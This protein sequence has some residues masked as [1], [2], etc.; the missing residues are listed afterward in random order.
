MP[1]VRSL[2][3][4]I[5]ISDAFALAEALAS[6]ALLQPVEGAVVAPPW[7]LRMHGFGAH[8]PDELQA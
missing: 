3:I 2:I 5:I 1:A 8:P 7:S 6:I 4:I